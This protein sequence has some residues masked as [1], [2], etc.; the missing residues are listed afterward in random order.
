MNLCISNGTV[1]TKIYNKRDTVNFTFLDGDV[2]RRTSYGVYIYQLIR[3]AR[4]SS[5]L[6]DFNSRNKALTAKLLRQGYRYF[7]LRKAFS[8]FYRRH[9]ALVEKYSVSLKTLLQ[10]GISESEFYGDLVYRFRKIVGKSII[11]EQFRKLINRY[12]R[13][14]Y[15]LDIT[16]QT[17]CLVVNPII[18]D[19]MLHS[20]ITRRRFGPQTQWRPLCKT[21]TSGLGLDDM[22]LA[23]PAVVQLLVFIYSGI[24]RNSHT[25]SSL[26]VIVINLIFM[27]WCIDWVGS[28]YA[29]GFFMYLCIKS[30]IGTQGEVG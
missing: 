14:G 22:S 11:S 27:F 13:I 28:L 8:K 30:S 20:L 4:A 29:N 25:Y 18:V 19:A 5:N 9:S 6:S 16:R 1:F 15:S 7:K 23:W 21:L 3:F 24:S 10:Q 17:P 2:P 26:F 12:K